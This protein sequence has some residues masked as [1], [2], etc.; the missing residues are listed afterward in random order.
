MNLN[1][2]IYGSPLLSDSLE[3]WLLDNALFLQDP[4]NCEKD[5]VYKNPQLLREDD[6]EFITTFSLRSHSKNID[7]QQ[8]ETR[9]DLF[10]LLN[11]EHHLTETEAPPVVLTPL[12]SYINNVTGSVERDKPP[13][14]CG[15]LLADQMGLGKSLN[16]ISLI[17]L[18]P[19][20]GLADS[21]L[22]YPG[23]LKPSRATLLVV[24]LPLL[25]TWDTQLRKHLASNSLSW[26]IFHGPSRLQLEELVHF[27]VVITTYKIV[28]LQWR[29]YGQKGSEES[30]SSAL[31]SLFSVFWHRIV[32]DEAHI[33]QNPATII[34]KSACAIQARHRWAV[35]GTPIQNR[36]TDLAS[37]FKFLQVYPYSNPQVFDK[38]I[39]QP[40][41]RNDRIGC[42]RVKTLVNFVTLFRTRSVIDL[43]DRHDEIYHLRF[44]PEESD[45]YQQVKLRTAGAVAEAIA[46]K[47]RGKFRNALSWLNQLR[48]I[49]NHGLMQSRKPIVHSS[50]GTWTSVRAQSMI[51]EMLDNGNAFFIKD[52]AIFY[53]RIDGKISA[54]HR[55][56]AIQRFQEDPDIQVILVS[57]TCGGAGLD[58]TAGSTVYLME[59][60]WNPMI[61]E[62]AICR[63]HRIG[64]KKAVKTIRY[65]IRD[66]FEEKVVKIQ[67]RKK[68]LAALTVSN[69]GITE[70]DL[71]LTRLQVSAYL[72]NIEQ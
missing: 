65:R 9:P 31:N 13:D 51:K 33:I 26:T 64:Q 38:E 61:E 43:P 67:E 44:S 40:W 54:N 21:N 16:V 2:I 57:I 18:H 68:D 11:V 30:T 25:E 20:R 5:V 7:V 23:L 8:I 66:S 42:L 46:S 37:L 53:T 6:E 58:L 35:T 69:G 70:A 27:D 24:P 15:G 29:Q 56:T 45:I 60:Q 1:I 28:S 14:F 47:G 4:I 52:A 17:A 72:P 41:Q 12:Y 34:A 55:A 48:L 49:C 22:T 19:Y 63:A 10:E 71:D 39:S 50:K 36:L 32:L 62:Q 3:E 59:P